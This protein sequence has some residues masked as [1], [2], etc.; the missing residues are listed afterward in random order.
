LLVFRESAGRE[1]YPSATLIREL[2]S[3]LRSAN[4]HQG[5]RRHELLTNALL[6]AGEMECALADLRHPAASAAESLSD[7]I[8]RELLWRK[9]DYP[10]ALARLAAQHLPESLTITTPEGFAYYALDPLRY[11]EAIHESGVERAFVVGIRSIGTVLSAVSAAALH[12]ERITVRPT[13][14]PYDRELR[15]RAEQSAVIRRQ[16]ER[17]ARF[18]IAD[19]GPGLSGSS[20]L[21]TAEAIEREGVPP[22]DI[23]LIGSHDC[24][25]ANLV[26]RDAAARWKRYHFVAIAP[27]A[28]PAGARPFHD[29][30]WRRESPI[31]ER[32]WPATWSQL[33]PPKYISASGDLLWKYEGLGRAGDQV[34]RRADVL[35]TA[36][37]SPRL[38]AASHGFSAYPYV[39]GE[40]LR[41]EQWSVELAEQIGAY[42]AFRRSGFAAPAD[43][44]A[45]RE[46]VLHNARTLLGVDLVGYEL[47]VLSACICDARLM[48]HEWIR[49]EDGRILKTDATM[50]GD[51]HF[52]PG[53]CDIAWDVAGAIIEWKLNDASEADFVSRYERLSSDHVRHRL[54]Q[55]KIAYAAFRAAYACMAASSMPGTSEAERFTRA[56][57]RYMDVLRTEVRPF[58]PAKKVYA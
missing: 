44:A 46:M 18:F 54:P 1:H 13:G 26:V 56:C 7:E 31:D 40:P 48:P 4:S 55:Y 27:A 58:V 12:C 17:G 38:V 33:T 51:D 45:L 52:Y 10:S 49:S 19:E 36:G 16:V 6:R 43:S 20:F 22:A 15:F 41:Y 57:G 37:F 25:G 9:A 24:D 30:D 14:H 28:A 8:A 5:E 35:G 34:R 47:D 53:T 23:T 3:F 11:A 32:D 39:C 2:D 29:W 21:A 42:L 50:H